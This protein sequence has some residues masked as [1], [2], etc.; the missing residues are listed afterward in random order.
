MKI[1]YKVGNLLDIKAG[2]IVHGCNAQGVMGCGVALAIRNMYPECYEDYRAIYEDEG[3]NLG[4]AYPYLPSTD[5][6]IWNAITQEF[7]GHDQR[8][9]SYD[10]IQTCFNEINC[11]ILEADLDIVKE[12]HIPF[13]GAGLAKGRW[14]IISAIIED[15]C[16]VPVTVWSIDG[17]MPDGSV[18]P[19]D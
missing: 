5:L 3:L 12:I 6:V 13:I 15:T 10:A 16:T 17:K 8:Y 9:V 4:W 2:N 18:L 1:V 14:P 11:A 19:I 7:C